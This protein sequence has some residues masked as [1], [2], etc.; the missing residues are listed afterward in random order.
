MKEN[1][2]L[3]E[4]PED[5]KEGLGQFL[6]NDEPEN[7]EVKADESEVKEPVNEIIKDVVNEK[8]EDSSLISLNELLDGKFKTKDELIEALKQ[9]KDAGISEEL[10]KAIAEKERIEKEYNEAKSNFKISDETL[11]K[12]DKLS[13]ENK[14]DFQVAAKL[15]YGNPNPID[16]LKIK[17]KREHPQLT[18]EQI[19]EYI[20]DKY[21]VEIPSELV[22]DEYT[23]DEI[24]T[25]KKQIEKAK[26]KASIQ[27]TQ[28]T[29]DSADAKKELVKILDKYE[30]P[31]TLTEEE[32]TNLANQ[33]QEEEKAKTQAFVDSWK[34]VFKDVSK[35]IGT[36]KVN[37]KG[38]KEDTEKHFMDIEI[39]KEEQQKYLEQAADY[40]LNSRVDVKPDS[41]E[42]IREFIFNRYV[43]DNKSR[44]FY[45][46]GEQARKL[47]DEEWKKQ[48][49]NPSGTQNKDVSTTADSKSDLEKFSEEVIKKM[50][51]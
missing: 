5:I 15:L 12:L 21:D 31:K 8:K 23:E 17:H 11:Y 2:N 48:I 51:L 6:P 40:I 41:S 42:Q 19:E 32:K 30:L 10:E 7:K 22:G 13:V 9:E 26:R 35:E 34:P 49:D 18:D 1:E 27:N 29:I 33:K 24:N 46:I 47:N 25:R 43:N 14:D 50:D 3:N 44:V 39:P 38:E 16:V 4:M 20:N 36:F 37:I 28:I 45:E